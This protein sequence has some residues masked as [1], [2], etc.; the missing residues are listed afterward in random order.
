MKINS[1][2]KGHQ[3]ER[4]FANQFKVL[5]WP[6]AIRKLE[7]QASN[8]LDGIDLLNTYPFLVQAKCRKDYVPVNTINEVKEKKGQYALLIT[9]GKN[10]EAMAVMRWDDLKELLC[11]LKTEE[12][13]KIPIS[14]LNP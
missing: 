8:A 10:K 4:D 2:R 3:F 13:L 14:T 9:K 12:I 6:Q 7:Y 11:M 1:R 5:G